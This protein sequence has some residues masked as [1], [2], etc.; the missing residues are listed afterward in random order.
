MFLAS[1]KIAGLAILQIF[2]LAALGFL[3]RKKGILEETG[4]TSLSQ[5]VVEVTLPAL[6][7]C[8]LVRDFS[9]SLYP[10]WWVFPILSLAVCLAGFLLGLPFSG[11]LGSRQKRWQFLSLVSFQNS[12]YLPLA[13][14]A[15]MLPEEQAT[16]LFI[17][18]F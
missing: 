2:L 1:F 8:Q 12:G 6:I 7:F 10:Q 15:A 11:L 9:F 4:L 16:P 3:L 18:L 17:Y 5:I 13:L 14:I